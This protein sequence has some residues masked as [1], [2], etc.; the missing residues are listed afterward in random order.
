LAALLVAAAQVAASA[1]EDDHDDGDILLIGDNSQVED[2]LE[3]MLERDARRA[4]TFKPPVTHPPQF[5]L[6]SRDRVS[7]QCAHGTAP[8]FAGLCRSNR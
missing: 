6:A 4:G 7:G 3:L 2:V 5:V 8:A 1:V